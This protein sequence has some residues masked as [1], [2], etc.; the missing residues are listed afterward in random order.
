MED[1]W[2]SGALELLKHAD[3]HIE[4]DTAFDSRMAFVSIDNSVET[5]IRVFMSLPEKTSG[6]KFTRK[7]VNEVEGSFPRMVELVF[8]KNLFLQDT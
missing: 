7:E 4:L 2:A 3:S 5:S 6:I 1:T 8:Q